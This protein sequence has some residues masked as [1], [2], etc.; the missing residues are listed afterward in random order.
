MV[1]HLLCLLMLLHSTEGAAARSSII[2]G[3]DAEVG[4]WPWMVHI[5]ITHNRTTKWRCG[6]TIL[7][8]EWV[9]TAAHCLDRQL[10]VDEQQSFV[11]VGKHDLQKGW[12]GYK[13]IKTFVL[14]PSYNGVSNSHDYD[15]ALINLKRKLNFNPNVSAISLPKASDIFNETSDCWITGWGQIGNGVPLPPP[16]TLQQLKIPLVP[17][18]IC[19]KTYPHLTSNMLCAGAEGK[20]GCEGD[21]GGPL[22]CKTPSGLVQV[23]IMSSRSPGGCGLPGQPG[24]YTQVSGFVDYIQRRI[25]HTKE[26][27]AEA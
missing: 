21:D 14:H 2:G 3:S 27:S 10:K 16:E 25:N 9:M 11:A 20:D 23:G 1:L 22:V 17:H 13:D 5:N 4:A 12:G 7:N 15:L 24:I 26:G 8:E 6:G 19:K 18:S